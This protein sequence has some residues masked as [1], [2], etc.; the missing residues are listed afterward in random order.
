LGQGS[1]AAASVHEDRRSEGRRGL[2]TAFRLAGEGSLST[3]HPKVK[4][5]SHAKPGQLD[6]ASH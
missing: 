1:E 4:S 6:D 2:L 5:K 3:S